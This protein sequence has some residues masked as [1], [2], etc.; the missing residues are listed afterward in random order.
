[1]TDVQEYVSGRALLERARSVLEPL[2]AMAATDRAHLR[3]AGVEAKVDALFTG[4]PLPNHVLFNPAMQSVAK[5]LS[6]A[7]FEWFIA[8]QDRR[9][10]RTAAH[11]LWA[12]GKA[13]YAL[14]PHLLTYLSTGSVERGLPTAMLDRIKRPNPF[15]LLPEEPLPKKIAKVVEGTMLARPLQGCYLSGKRRGGTLLC[16]L[17]DP[18]RDSLGLLFVFPVRVDGQISSE[19]P[20]SGAWLEAEFLRAT[21]PLDGTTFSLDDA[22]EETAARFRYNEFMDEQT[23]RPWLTWAVRRVLL[24]VLYLCTDAPDE[25]TFRRGEAKAK[26]AAAKRGKR[27]PKPKASG[28]R[29]EEIVQVGFKLGPTLHRARMQAEQRGSAKVEERGEGAGGW[30][31]PPHLRGPSPYALYWTGPGGSIPAFRGR[32]EYWVHKEE[33]EAGQE[34]SGPVTVIPVK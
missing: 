26:A 34:A 19:K 31:Q 5:N 21:V 27:T 9:A 23:L 3:V 22:V 13:V 30:R 6:E 18:Q 7:D 2:S 32:R 1:M 20:R 33:L 17:A 11:E 8:E 4:H 25:E 14:H 24:S 28:D 15:L 29:V 10:R 12:R 16:D